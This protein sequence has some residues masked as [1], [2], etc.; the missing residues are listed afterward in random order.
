[1][2]GWKWPSLWKTGDIPSTE[3]CGGYSAF[4]QNHWDLSFCVSAAFHFP[5]LPALCEELQSSCSRTVF[6]HSG[7]PCSCNKRS[8]VYLY[9]AQ[10]FTIIW[11]FRA[12]VWALLCEDEKKLSVLCGGYKSETVVN[13]FSV[14]KSKEFELLLWKKD[15]RQVYS[16]SC[17]AAGYEGFAGVHVKAHIY[18]SLIYCL[19]QELSLV[20]ACLRQQMELLR[21]NSL[22]LA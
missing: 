11:L 19:V 14:V 22:K 12:W 13:G 21:S 2:W 6:R 17:G 5:H 3:C 1:M 15:E 8:S 18:W 16:S 7:N 10:S 20:T 9:L 4:L